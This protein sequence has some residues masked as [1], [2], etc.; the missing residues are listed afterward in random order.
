MGANVVY[1]PDFALTKSTTY[2]SKPS[3]SRE[4]RIVGFIYDL[5]EIGRTPA[6]IRF[7]IDG[8]AYVRGHRGLV[9]RGELLAIVGSQTQT[10][11]K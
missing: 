10:V 9:E 8:V 7:P 4:G 5:D 3:N 11:T 6:E 1:T 2:N